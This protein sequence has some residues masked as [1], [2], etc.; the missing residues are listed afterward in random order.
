MAQLDQLQAMEILSVYTL[1]WVDT[2]KMLRAAQNEDWDNLLSLEQSRSIQ[3]EKIL[4]LDKGNGGNPEFMTRK[5]ELI[6]SIISANEE[7]KLLTQQWMSKLKESLT[8]I[9]MDK[10]LKQAYAA[11]APD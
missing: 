8:I 5:A 10:R 3:V 9:G 7:I 1:A 4:Q 2:Q 6:R 11:S